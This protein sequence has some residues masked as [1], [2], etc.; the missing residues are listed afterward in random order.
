MVWAVCATGAQPTHG[1]LTNIVIDAEL[2]VR[3]DDAYN[4]QSLAVATLRDIEATVEQCRAQE[5]REPQLRMTRSEYDASQPE[6]KAE[7]ARIGPRELR[8]VRKLLI[9]IAFLDRHR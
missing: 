3:Q 4:A 7:G 6:R 8:Q 1:N 2:T 5:R 9:H